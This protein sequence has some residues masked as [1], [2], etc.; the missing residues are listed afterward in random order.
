MG[1]NSLSLGGVESDPTTVTLAPGRYR[2]IATRGPEYELVEVVIEA[3]A[4]E[5]RSLPLVA[6]ARAIETPGWIAADLHVHSAASFDSGIAYTERVRS[7]A[8]QGGE[9]LVATDH[10]RVFDLAPAIAELGMSTSIAS[11]VGVE[12]TSILHSEAAPYGYGHANAFPLPVRPE[13]F[14][15][16][17]PTS[18][19]V[20]LSAMMA[21]VRELPGVRVVQLNHPRTGSGE[22]SDESLFTHLSVAGRA[23][24]PTLPLDADPNR[25]L[26]ERDPSSG[27]RDLDYD[28]VELLNGPTWP[29][30]DYY[31]R[32]RADWFSMLLQGEVRTATANSDSHRLEKPVGV[33]RTY[34]PQADDRPSAF[35]EQAFVAALRQGRVF[36]T[37]GPFIELD[38]GGAGMGDRF[39]GRSATLSLRVRAAAWAAADRARVFVNGRLISELPLESDGSARWTLDFDRDAFVTV[40]VEG[41]AGE[42]FA[43]VLPNS[44]PFAFSNP[45]FVDADADGKWTAPGLPDDRDDLPPSLTDPVPAP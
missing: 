19:G 30:L 27:L 31:K 12:S 4:G 14:R 18:Q 3:R 20:R 26:L 6:P 10:D 17:A 13:L 34:I 38:L 29:G 7:F 43:A 23:F 8:A 25:V 1:T 16:G 41:D 39:T 35:D 15:N 33:P 11:V 32:V 9:V 36:G 42:G 24:D 44:V 37:T 21:E 28:A 5:T 22:P 2:V 45:I 40:E